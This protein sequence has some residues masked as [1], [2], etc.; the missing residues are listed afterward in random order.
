MKGAH[1][2]TRLCMLWVVA[3]GLILASGSV[4]KAD[5]V[6]EGWTLAPGLT[7]EAIYD[8][9]GGNYTLTFII[10]NANSA[11]AGIYDWTLGLVTGGAITVDAYSGDGTEQTGFA[12]YPNLKQNNGSGVICSDGNT[13]NGNLCIDYTG[14]FGTIFGN[15]SLTYNLSGTYTGS[16]VTTI[17]LMAQG[18]VEVDGENCAYNGAGSYNVSQDGTAV[19]E[20]GSLLLFGTGLLGVAGYLRRRLL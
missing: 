7:A 5:T 8:A 16:P 3:I 11:D 1:K 4:A 15:D 17:H 20:P 2:L 12:P 13:N 6:D 10:T 14:G 19:P 9:S 18:C